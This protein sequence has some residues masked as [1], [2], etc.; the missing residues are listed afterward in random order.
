MKYIRLTNSKRVLQN[1][2]YEFDYVYLNEFDG[3][4]FKTHIIIYKE[5]ADVYPNFDFY[6]EIYFP[7][8]DYIVKFKIVLS[9]PEKRCVEKHFT[10]EYFEEQFFKFFEMFHGKQIFKQYIEVTGNAEVQPVSAI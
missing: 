6:A 8:K 7:C 1:V 4:S 3:K 9:P 10:P 5:K 2:V